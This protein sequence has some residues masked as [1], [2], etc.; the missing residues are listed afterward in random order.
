VKLRILQYLA[1]KID[2]GYD[3]VITN[4]AEYGFFAQA[5]AFPAEGMVH[6]STLRD[7]YYVFDADEYSLRGQRS[8]TRFRLGDEVR[9]EVARVDLAKRQ[10][11]WRLVERKIRSAKPKPDSFPKPF[12]KARSGKPKGLPKARKKHK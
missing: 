1:D 8:Q 10:L 4:V 12:P 5:T 11:D 7:D 6:V 9:V 2:T 3:A